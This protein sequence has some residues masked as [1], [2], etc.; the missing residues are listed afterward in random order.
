MNRWL[1]TPA[2]NSAIFLAEASTVGLARQ[3]F[4]RIASGVERR[5][6]RHLV[7]E[8]LDRRQQRQLPAE[9]ALHQPA[10]DDQPVDFVGALE[11]SVDARIA[12]VALR[13][14]LLDVAVA[15]HGG[16][17]LVGH[18]RQHLRA[19]DLQDGALD[20]VLLDAPSGSRAA[21]WACSGPSAAS[22]ASIMPTVR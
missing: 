18:Q 14:I 12:V 10:G 6:L 22:P 8:L 16:D 7:H 11:D 21:L 17:Q 4:A 9:R 19:I 20:G 13:R 3:R 15:A 2:A 5:R 1:A